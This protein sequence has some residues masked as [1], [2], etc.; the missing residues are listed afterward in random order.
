[1]SK[2]IC[3]VTFAV[4]T[5]A[6]AAMAESA[7]PDLRGTWKGDSET[8][9]LG[10]GNLHHTATQ[11][12]EPELRSVSFT[13]KVDKQDGRRFLRDLLVGARRH[14]S[15]C[16]HFAQRHNPYGRRGR[17]H[18]RH[19][20]GAEPDGDLLSKTV[21]GRAH[22]ILHGVDQAAI[23]TTADIAG[24]TAGPPVPSMVSSDGAICSHIRHGDR[25]RRGLQ[26]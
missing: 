20:A 11:A 23:T 5:A 4:F 9:V 21:A 2:L 7:I 10:G 18:Q 15:H 25:G 16:R 22:R 14:E 12:D 26:V 8:I 3:I 6:T 19:N 13:L 24:G 17:L 1:M